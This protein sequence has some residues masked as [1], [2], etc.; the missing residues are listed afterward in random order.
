MDCPVQLNLIPAHLDAIR[1]ENLLIGLWLGGERWLRLH[2]KLVSAFVFFH[3]RQDGEALISIRAEDHRMPQ[4][5]HGRWWTE[6]PELVVALGGGTI[7]ASY[8]V[9]DDVLYW[10]DEVLIRRS[11]D[12]RQA[13]ALAA[14][15]AAASVAASDAASDVAQIAAQ[16]A[17]PAADPL[18]RYEE[19]GSGPAW[20]LNFQL[21]D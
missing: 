2:G 7:R 20:R 4:R 3:L 17:Q 12:S 19:S 13:S 9:A 21:G 10:A 5:V 14:A 15:S 11:E 8:T 6:G 16:I 1:D 18:R